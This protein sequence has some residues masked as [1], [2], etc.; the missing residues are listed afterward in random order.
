[1]SKGTKQTI[2]EWEQKNPRALAVR[3]LEKIQ[4]GAYSNLQLNQIAKQSKLDERDIHLLTTLTYG[5]IQHR[6]T[7]E[8]WL[9]PFVKDLT[10]LDAWVKE[11]LFISLFQMQYL[12]KIPNHAIFDEAIQIAKRRGHDGVRKFVTGVLHAIDRQGVPD[13]ATIT[14][15]TERLSIGSSLPVWLIEE[16]TKELGLE[17]TT[18]IANAINEAPAQSARVNLAV[19]TVAEASY[20]LQAEGLTVTASEVS[21]DAL[22][23]TGGHVASSHAF[24]NGLITLQDESA[25]LMAPSLAIEPNMHVLDA[26]A[27]PGGKTTQIATYLD[28]AAGGLVDALDIHDHKVKLIEQNAARLQVSDRIKAQNLDARKVDEQFSDESFDR[29]LVDAPCTGFGLLRRKPEIRYDKTIQDSLSLQKIQ[30]EILNAVAPKLKKGGRMV[31]GTCTIL[32]AE[33]ED[34]VH[35]FIAN[36]PDFALIPTYTAYELNALDA[37]GMLHM[38]PDDHASDGFFIATLQKQA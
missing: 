35:A 18:A 21:P 33:N 32:K 15:P 38:F 34:V 29:I 19:T 12:D 4:N 5:V 20:A 26:A 8:Y 25:M 24:A 14:D 6:L 11:L 37:E 13:F 22:L 3:T 23:I 30:L 9:Q 1:M 16:L 36:N 31:Y 17:K 2:A 27:A 10:K 28:A 7:L